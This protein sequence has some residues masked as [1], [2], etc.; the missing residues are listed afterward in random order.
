MELLSSFLGSMDVIQWVFLGLGVI[1]VAPV[2]LDFFSKF[3]SV[4]VKRSSSND[5]GDLITKWETLADAV[6]EA[7]INEACDLLDEVFPLLIHVRDEEVNVEP[8]GY[9]DK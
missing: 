2:L 4:K 7:G 8:E 9:D 3:K 5:L 1:L 6:H